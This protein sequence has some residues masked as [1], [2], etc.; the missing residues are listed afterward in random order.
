MEHTIKATP[1]DFYF[2]YLTSIRGILDLSSKERMVLGEFM[3]IQ[4]YL[5]AKG[6]DISPFS[7]DN[8]KL[9]QKSLKMSSYSVNNYIKTLRSKRVVTGEEGS[10]QVNKG[11]IPKVE[12]GRYRVAFNF[13][14]G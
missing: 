3:K 2:K 14:I 13:D 9:V 10:L 7:S 6:S 4:S 12:D 8:R 5:V 1:N 11:I